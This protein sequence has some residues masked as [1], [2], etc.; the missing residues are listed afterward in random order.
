M[1]H[2]FYIPVMGTGFTIDTPLFVAKWG[3]SSVISL[4]DDVLIE[5]MRK[6]WCERTNRL[7][8]AIKQSD[9]DHRAKRIQ[10][11]LNLLYDLIQEEFNKLKQQQ[12]GVNSELDRY[13]KQLCDASPLKKL[14]ETCLAQ[15]DNFKRNDLIT[16]L[17]DKLSLGRIEA[18]IMTKL[19]VPQWQGDAQLPYIYNDAAAALRGYATS[20]LTNSSIVMS[21][22]FN[23]ALYNYLTEF[24]DFVPNANGHLIKEICL[25]VSD[26]RS[27]MIQGKYLAKKGL[28]VSEF[29]IESAINCGGH[30]FIN[31]GSLLGPILEEFT[32]KKEALIAELFSFYQ[33]ALAKRKGVTLASPLPVKISVQGGVGT[34]S[35]HQFLLN[36]Y[37]LSAVGW[38]SPFL[39]V[40]EVTN[41]DHDTLK[42]L[43]AGADNIFLSRS[44]PIGVP[45]WNLKNSSSE[46]HR[47]ALI[48][49]NNPGSPCPKGFTRV[50]QDVSGRPI[51]R[52]SR[53]FQL[54][55]LAKLDASTESSAIKAAKRKD[56]L[57]KSCICHELGNGVLLKNGQL[58]QGFVAVCPGPNLKYFNAITSLEG[59]IDH[60][61]GRKELKLKPRANLFINELN[62]QIQQ[63]KEDLAR[64]KLNLPARTRQELSDVAAKLLSGIEYYHKL[65]A[66]L[67]KAMQ[68]DFKQQ[69]DKAAADISHLCLTT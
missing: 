60:I 24:D 36:N 31:D 63:L 56:I 21:A 38:G 12:I 45:F 65:A 5:Q 7:Y 43:A 62:L 66:K 51:C 64:D 59:M 26:F 29:R 8:Q 6:Y 39:L 52:A 1:T 2:S 61:Y 27:A 69:L 3:I 40:P 20:K 44:S 50:A 13:F 34:S 16:Q 4:V 49:A 57:A 54:D 32:A 17:K 9:L 48:E 15:L 53:K 35:E 28:W 10:A 22:G 18:N 37:N 19:D 42:K 46:Q 14:Y 23:G 58:K 30:A 33:P 67:P 68:L 47:E 41:V 55:A 11:Y 25:K